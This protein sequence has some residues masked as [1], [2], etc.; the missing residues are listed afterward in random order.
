MIG[1]ALADAMGPDFARLDP[2]IQATH[3]GRIRLSGTV[4][5]KRGR[6]LGGWLAG[7]LKMP[8]SNPAC[9]MVV[10]GDHQPDV[11]LWS[12]DFAGHKM[13]SAFRRDGAYLTER[14]GPI[15]L[16]LKPVVQNGS[17]IYRLVSARVG[18]LP[19]PGLLK[20]HLEASERES[21]G[22]YD[23]AVD[24]GLPLIGRLIRYRGQLV[25]ATSASA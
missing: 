1:N 13:V 18:F 20:P 11:M 10:D 5:V 4:E 21:D 7:I 8:A 23:F 6:G 2:L 15:A 25:L 16:R 12:R 17:L 22:C 3:R 9:A 24:V 14:M 19:L